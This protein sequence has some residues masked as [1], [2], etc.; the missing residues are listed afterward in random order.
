[1]SFFIV[2][3]PIGNLN[4]FSA[5]SIEILRS[6]K[7]ILCEKK[8]RALKLLNYYKIRPNQLIAYHDDKSEK[9][10]P[11]IVSEI[12]NNE[13]ISL[14]SDAGTPLI[15]DPGHKIIRILVENSI[16]PIT[17]PGPSSIISALT[18]STID[19]SNFIFLG[20]LPKNKKKIIQILQDKIY[21]GMPLVVFS[22]SKELKVLIRLLNLN[23][24]HF[25]ISISKEISKINESTRRG[26]V[27]ELEKSLQDEFFQKGEFVIVI[28]GKLKEES[29][30]TKEEI[31]KLL[32]SLKSEGLTLKQSMN[33]IKKLNETNK[34]LTYELALKIWDN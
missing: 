14:I 34:N 31:L 10:A 15:S 30:S 33:I 13:N 29:D 1:M 32:K 16:E 23:Y 9:I 19:I 18:L 11:L 28:Q 27:L 25:F 5:R 21:L 24:K 7:I 20:F 12:R 4:D 8:T 3:T 2:P 26:I 17:V 6:S 22:S